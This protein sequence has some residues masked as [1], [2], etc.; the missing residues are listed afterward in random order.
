MM[1]KLGGLL[2]GAL[3]LLPLVMLVYVIYTWNK[4]K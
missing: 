3:L 1:G 4:N 2:A